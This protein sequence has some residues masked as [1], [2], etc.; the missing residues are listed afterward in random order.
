ME[1]LVSTPL[2]L[3][4]ADEM[5]AALGLERKPVVLDLDPVASTFGMRQAQRRP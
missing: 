2:V 4:C 3:T 1:V 5:P